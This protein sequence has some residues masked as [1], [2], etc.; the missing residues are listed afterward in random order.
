MNKTREIFEK[1]LFFKI[2][3]IVIEVSLVF[4]LFNGNSLLVL[5]LIS[6]LLILL[7]NLFMNLW[8]ELNRERIKRND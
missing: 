7:I 2:L 1:I 6:I 4:C 3:F 5:G 8:E